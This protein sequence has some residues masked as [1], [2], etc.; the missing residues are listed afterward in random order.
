[1]LAHPCRRGQQARALLAWSRP[2]RWAAVTQVLVAA[3][4][5]L[6][7]VPLAAH[8]VLPAALPELLAAA[9]RPQ[10]PLAARRLLQVMRGLAALLPHLAA[11]LQAPRAWLAQ[12]ALQAVRVAAA[13][14]QLQPAALMHPLLPLQH[15]LAQLQLVLLAR[16]H[17][18]HRPLAQ[19]Q[20]ALLARP[21]LL[22]H[23]LALL[24]LAMGLPAQTTR[25]LLLR[26]QQAL[27]RAHA[28]C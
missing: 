16:P 9:R 3:A 13:L 23:L 17:L 2:L 19:L 15:Q 4:A 27:P 24:C 12:A 21:R 6:Q 11:R 20:Q 18:L 5:R 25:L 7:L 14:S 8:W 22:R 1:M 26:R 10:A 28:G